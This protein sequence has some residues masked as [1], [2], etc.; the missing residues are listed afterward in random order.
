M[1]IYAIIYVNVNVRVM[2][3]VSWMEWNV[4]NYKIQS[5]YFVA[6]NSNSN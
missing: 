1:Q 5:D 6:G 4:I 3:G 2:E